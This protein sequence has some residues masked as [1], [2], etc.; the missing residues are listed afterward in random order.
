MI[1]FHTGQDDMVRTIMEKLRPLIKKGSVVF[2]SFDDYM[3]PFSRTPTTAKINRHSADEK[4]GLQACAREYPGREGG[5]RSFPM[6]ARNDKRLPLADE[7]GPQRL[8]E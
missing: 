6:R 3:I 4:A 7:K 5:R 2:I 1:K 8:R